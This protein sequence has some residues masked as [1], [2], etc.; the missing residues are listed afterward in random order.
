LVGGSAVG[1]SGDITAQGT[2]PQAYEQPTTIF[3]G[4]GTSAS[5]PNGV[6]NTIIFSVPQTKFMNNYQLRVIVADPQNGA[7]TAS[8]GFAV[9]QPSGALNGISWRSLQSNSVVAWFVENGVHTSSQT[10]GVPPDSTWVPSATGDVNGDGFTDIV[11][12]SSA[13][14]LIVIWFLDAQ[15]SLIA[16]ASPG[17]VPDGDWTIVDAADANA[18]GNA[19]LLWFNTSTLSLVQWLLTPNGGLSASRVIATAPSGWTP[20]AFRSFNADAVADIA[21]QQAGSKGAIAIWYLNASGAVTGST[22]VGNTG[23]S[24]WQLRTAARVFSTEESLVFQNTASGQ[25]FYWRLSPSGT[26]IST[27]SLGSLPPALWV[28]F[29]GCRF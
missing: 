21:W 24:T 11:W 28:A 4:N 13:S 6:T 2:N 18:S 27:G 26:I 22:I 3:L 16:T 12:R 23:S 14:G 29:G 20:R 7:A 9:R 17:S 15:Y 10:L 5:G 8:V 19:D 1:F 25:V